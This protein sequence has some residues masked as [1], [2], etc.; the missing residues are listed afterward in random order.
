V[1][2]RVPLG[3]FKRLDL[4]YMYSIIYGI[5]LGGPQRIGIKVQVLVYLLA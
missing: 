3:S 1:G 2:Q 4:N 5:F